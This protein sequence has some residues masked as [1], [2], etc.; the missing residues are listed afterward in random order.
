MVECQVSTLDM[1]VR[2]P[3]PALNGLVAQ[4]GERVN[5]IHEVMGSIPIRSIRKCKEVNIYKRE[6]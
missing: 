4:L 6:K 2:F 5:G 3:S 1:R